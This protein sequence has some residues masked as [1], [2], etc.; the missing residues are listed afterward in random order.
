MLA[1]RPPRDPELILDVGTGRRI[2]AIGYAKENPTVR[3]VC[4][5]IWNEGEIRANSPRG[6]S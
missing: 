3:V 1:K 4:I 5:D 2:I 6:S